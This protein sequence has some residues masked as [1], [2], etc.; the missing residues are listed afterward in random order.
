MIQKKKIFFFSC[1]WYEINVTVKSCFFFPHS[2]PLPRNSYLSD[3]QRTAVDELMTTINKCSI[4]DSFY[5]SYH[6]RRQCY[7]KKIEYQVQEQSRIRIRTG[8]WE[9][10]IRVALQPKFNA[11]LCFKS[12]I[13][14]C[15]FDFRYTSVIIQ[16]R[17][18]KIK[19][20]IFFCFLMQS[21]PSYLSISSAQ[22]LVYFNPITTQ[23]QCCDHSSVFSA[24]E[25]KNAIIL[26]AKKKKHL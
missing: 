25:K 1:F 14:H 3:Y 9:S 16:W 7:V 2:L 19:T 4:S 5:I 23:S 15:Q 26:L 20:L 17:A 12:S 8:I 10:S 22:L 21:P 24:G 13:N 11:Y 18:K 6:R